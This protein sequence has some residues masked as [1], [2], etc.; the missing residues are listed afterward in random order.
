MAYS[1]GKMIH[2]K[3][4][5][6]VKRLEHSSKAKL[7]K[8][9]I[10]SFKFGIFGRHYLAFEILN[11]ATSRE[12]PVVQPNVLAHYSL[13]TETSLVGKQASKFLLCPFFES[14]KKPTIQSIYF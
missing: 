1:C 4:M 2:K 9:H 7:K 10:L 6:C 14:L 5:L 12:K 8:S 11:S 3:C 13:R